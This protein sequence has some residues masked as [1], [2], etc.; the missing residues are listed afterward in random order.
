MAGDGDGTVREG[1]EEA[2]GAG[3]MA[4]S[5]HRLKVKRVYDRHPLTAALHS[6]TSELNPL[7]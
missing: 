7:T 6:L 3:V 2:G 4:R 5:P 1:R